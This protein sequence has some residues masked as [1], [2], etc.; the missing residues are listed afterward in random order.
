MG[1]IILHL[2]HPD[3]CKECAFYDN[4]IGVCK[5]DDYANH[6]YEVFCVWHYCPYKKVRAD[7]GEEDCNGN[8]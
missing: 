8:T 5:S 1:E 7:A 4:K 2:R 3:Y 6:I